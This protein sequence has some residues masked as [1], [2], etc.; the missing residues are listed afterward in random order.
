MLCRD[1]SGFSRHLVRRRA[2]AARGQGF[3]KPRSCEI[4]SHPPIARP[5]WILR[6]RGRR[7]D[8][9][10]VEIAGWHDDD[11]RSRCLLGRVVNVAKTTYHGYEVSTLPPPAQT[12][13][14]DELLNILESC[15]PIWAPGQTLA[16]L[17]PANPKFWHFVVEAKKLAYRDV[18]AHNG[19]PK[20]SSIPLDRLL[21][22]PYATSLCGQVNPDRASRTGPP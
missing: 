10:Q 5:R 19:D 6:G 16:S 9:R 18:F 21:S 11:G 8:R 15:V 13:A 20:F 7:G 17:G 22:K 2:A 1:R 4:V 3:S 14:T 12:W